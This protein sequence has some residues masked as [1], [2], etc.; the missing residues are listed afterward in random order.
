MN[1]FWLKVAGVGVLAVVALIVVVQFTGEDKEE[2]VQDENAQSGSANVYEQDAKDHERFNAPIQVVPDERAPVQVET[3]VAPV[4]QVPEPVAVPEFAKLTAE[5]QVAA[6]R[7]WEMAET[8]FKIGR[9][10][11]MTFGNCV[12]Y[13]RQIIE[14]FPDSE[15]ALR[16]KRVLNEI[17]EMRDQ[18]KSQYHITDEELDMGAFK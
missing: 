2:V 10:P 17:V 3:A 4:T 7:L 12:K 15:Y 11:M 18:Y 16:A 13:S 5:Q 14:Q 1:T 9:K 6:E 8:S